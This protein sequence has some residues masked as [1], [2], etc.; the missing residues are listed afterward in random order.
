MPF[1]QILRCPALPVQAILLWSKLCSAMF[2]THNG[3]TLALLV[4]SGGCQ[5]CYGQ[6]RFVWDCAAISAMAALLA[7]VAPIVAAA[8]EAAAHAAAEDGA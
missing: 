2:V 1:C 6:V 7:E 3:I 8:A 4:F 5:G